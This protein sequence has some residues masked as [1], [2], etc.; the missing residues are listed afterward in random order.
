MYQ[1]GEFSKLAVVPVSLLRYYDRI[2][3]FKPAKISDE[4]GYRLYTSNQLATLYRILALRDLGI[5][6][7]EIALIMERDISVDELKYTLNKREAEI[8]NTIQL[9]QAR[10]KRLR[11]R[12]KYLE[13][14]NDEP[15]FEVIVK[16][17]QPQYLL[18]H[19]GSDFMQ[20][21]NNL[22]KTYRPKNDEIFTIITH[23]EFLDTTGNDFEVGYVSDRVLAESVQVT[24]DIILETRPLESLDM[25]ASTLYTGTLGGSYEAYHA[26]CKWIAP[27]GFQIVG[28]NRE[29]YIEIDQWDMDAHIVLDVQFPILPVK[30]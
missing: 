12:I 7:E 27:N 19:R 1:I 16:P 2:D 29:Y 30:S 22:L 15:R 18:A 10:L 20:L 13:N 23:S 17:V 6:L 9:E 24:K 3:L 5:P 21:G 26:L 28:P 11:N 14:I 25:V 8:V 4:S